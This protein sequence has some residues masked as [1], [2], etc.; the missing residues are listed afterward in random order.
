MNKNKQ[1]WQLVALSAV[2]FLSACTSVGEHDTSADLY[3]TN[4]SQADSEHYHFLR[5]VYQVANDELSM[6]Q[7]LD[8]HESGASNRAS[9][10][11]ISE[12]YQKIL[13]ELP[14]LGK[15]AD[16]LIPFPGFQKLGEVGK[17]DSLAMAA[18]SKD[19]LHQSIHRQEVVIGHFK[20]A[21]V[22]T[23]STIREYAHQWL[24]TLKENLEKTKSMH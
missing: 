16:V 12:S 22:N 11:S 3:Y 6:R 14:A 23:N 2:T 21:S 10:G 5:E 17:Q 24:P 7:L 18:L 4:H 19:F 9:L 13:E 15:Q 8:A 1:I 20:N